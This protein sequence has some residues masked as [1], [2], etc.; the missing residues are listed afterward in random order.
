MAQKEGLDRSRKDVVKI[1]SPRAVFF[2][3]LLFGLYF[4][5]IGWM[6]WFDLNGKDGSIQ[7]IREEWIDSNI[8]MPLQ[9]VS[10]VTMGMW[11]VGYWRRLPPRRKKA[12]G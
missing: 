1:P 7:R 4:D 10:L 6:F 3:G 9:I 8:T 2:W 5:H 12:K 11:F